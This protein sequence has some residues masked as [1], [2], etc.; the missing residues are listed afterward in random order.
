[1]RNPKSGI[2]FLVWGMYKNIQNKI[3]CTVSLRMNLP[4]TWITGY[5]GR[6]HEIGSSMVS[7]MHMADHA[8]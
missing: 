6:N 4:G 7:L 2:M 5:T 3:I 8:P 1:M